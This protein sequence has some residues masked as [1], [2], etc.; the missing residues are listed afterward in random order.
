MLRSRK[1]DAKDKQ[2]ALIPNIYTIFFF[3]LKFSRNIQN[4]DF[5]ATISFNQP[6]IRLTM[7]YVAVRVLSVTVWSLAFMGTKYG[8]DRV[9]CS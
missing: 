9:R 5:S 1:Y 6:A 3:Y 4:S 8:L 7:S 2:E